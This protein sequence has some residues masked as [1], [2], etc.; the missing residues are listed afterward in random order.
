MTQPRL[1]APGP[2]ARLGAHPDAN[3]TTFSIWAPRAERVELA[4]VAT[5]RTQ[6]NVD[7]AVDGDG[8]W[9]VHVPGVGARTTYGYR[10]HGEWNPQGGLR[11]NPAKLLLD[12]YAY[13]ITGGVDY[14]G[15]IMDHTPDSNYRP[16]PTDSFRAVPLSV[17][18]EPTPPPTPIAQRRPLT[19]SVIYEMHAKGYTRNHPLVPE[20]QRGTYAG[21]AYPAVI[22]HLVQTGINAVQ[23]LPIHHFVS[24]PFVVGSGLSNYWGYNTLGFF[25]PHS[26]YCSVGTLGEQV[27][28]FKEMVSALHEAGIEVFLDVVYNHTGEGG[29]EGP[30]LSFRGIDHG[31]YYRLTDDN[32]NDYD[33]TGC[34][35]SFATGQPGVQRLVMDSLRYWVTEMGIDGFR[36]DLATT[37]IRNGDHHVDQ[38][39]PLK[40]AMLTDP[41]L[42][43]IKL[44]AEPWD[45]GPYGYQVGAW[46]PGWSEWNDRYRGL[47]R[48]YWRGH[49]TGVQDLATR[50]S[51]S[52]DLFDH[53]RPLSASVN[54]ITA[55]DGFT[56]RDMVTYD[57]KHNEANRENNR[58]GTDDNRSWNCGVEGET[59][60]PAINALRRRQVKNLLATLILSHGV[61]MLTA[62]DE[63]GRTQHGNNNAYC[64]DGPISWVDWATARDWDDVTDIART[65]LSLRHRHPVLR[66]EE[67]RH[68]TEVVDAHGKGLGRFDLAWLNGSTGEMEQGDWHDTGRDLL[69][70][71]SSD[72]SDAFILWLHG[73]HY[74]VEITLP[75]LPW[76]QSYQVLSHSGQ[77]GELPIADDVLAAGTQLHVPPRTFLLMRAN[78]PSTAAE[79][80]FAQAEISARIA[81]EAAEA[82]AQAVAEAE[83][84][85]VAEAEA[86]AAAAFTAAEAEAAAAHLADAAQLASEAEQPAANPARRRRSRKTDPPAT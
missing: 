66:P 73:G 65:L 23:L 22:D 29:H 11:F 35:N 15:P 36:F 33:V 5:D 62:G 83:A 34:G 6:T 69:G 51:G 79:L 82:A 21:L 61:P 74:P 2:E 14:H 59:D 80:A 60:D 20:H 64:Q 38:N 45:I 81:A 26:S 19:E 37:L 10:V 72:A 70:M 32:R 86:A 39:H 67:F 50:L 85:A 8:V 54:F 44:I 41:V 17:V 42:A 1:P 28:E 53:G 13:A 84:A 4:L 57:R 47:A 55:H 31:G 77:P 71:Y 76:G 63:F 75:G 25:A 9:T 46:G 12:P 52:P 56:M 48:D 68:R 78:V 7:M 30:T 16:D 58:D 49:N 27:Q 18:V 24:E 43:D 3:G 40:Q